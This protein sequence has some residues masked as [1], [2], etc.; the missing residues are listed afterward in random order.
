MRAALANGQTFDLCPANGTRFAGAAIDPE[1]VL[2]IPT[3]KDPVNAGAV[4]A[5]AILEHL[6]HGKPQRFSLVR[7][8]QVRLRQRV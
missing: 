8:Y 5:D 4:V 2:E 7:R 1:M 6:A 3:A